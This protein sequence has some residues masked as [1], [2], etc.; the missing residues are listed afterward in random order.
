L[1]RHHGRGFEPEASVYPDTEESQSSSH[2]LLFHVIT[3]AW[4]PFDQPQNITF[5]RATTVG[6]GLTS[7]NIVFSDAQGSQETKASEF[8]IVRTARSLTTL[9]Y[10]VIVGYFCFIALI[11][12]FASRK[13]GKSSA[14]FSLAGRNVP[15][16]VAGIS[17][18]A[19]GAS[20]LSMMSVPALAFASNL[21]F[22]FPVL[23][24]FVSY[25]VQ[26]RLIFPLL[27]RME[28]TSTYEYLERRFN[29]TLR[30]IAS[31]QCILFQ[32]FGRASVVLLLPSLAISATTGIDT[33]K[34]VLLMGCITTLYTA[35]GGFN[36]VVWTDVFQGILK[37]FAPLFMIALCLFSLPGGPKEF[38]DI[39][40][41]HH[42]FDFA[43]LTWDATL[44][45]VWI[46]L[47]QNFLAST[48]AQAGDQPTIQRVFS[49]TN[50]GGPPRCGHEHSLRNPHFDSGECVGCCHLRLFPCVSG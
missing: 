43:I 4:C 21:V 41:S 17:M 18:F 37:F 7:K 39:G 12:Y 19:T 11:G 34:S 45:A 16:W 22:L 32:T 3:D 23:I 13:H 10:A 5:A 15:W 31:A 35:L 30:L 50:E 2:A 20:A 25:F 14:D 38:F 9:D 27:R 49:F 26:S 40:L 47:L 8:Q 33:W 28:I 44:P 42:K 6:S 1:H 29:R 24:L 36:A 46:L 48:I